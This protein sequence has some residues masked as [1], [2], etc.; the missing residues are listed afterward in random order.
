MQH[1]FPQ[2]NIIQRESKNQLLQRTRRL[3]FTDKANKVKEAN[4]KVNAKEFKTVVVFLLLFLYWQKRAK[5]KRFRTWVAE[6][7]KRNKITEGKQ[8]KT[9]IKIHEAIST[10]TPTNSNAEWFVKSIF[11]W[12]SWKKKKSWHWAEHQDINL[13]LLIFIVHSVWIF[14]WRNSA[15]MNVMHR[16]IDAEILYLFVPGHSFSI[17]Y[18]DALFVRNFCI[19]YFYVAVGGSWR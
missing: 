16:L 13:S 7:K 10:E 14:L 18:Q 2:A 3:S 1:H 9:N 6:K 15:Y 12:T 4:A 17:E 8:I 19:F 11:R 5:E